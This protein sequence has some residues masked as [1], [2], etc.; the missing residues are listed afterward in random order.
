MGLY[1]LGMSRVPTLN[2]QGSPQNID[3]HCKQILRCRYALF[4][5][6]SGSVWGYLAAV[7]FI[8]A[9]MRK[10]FYQVR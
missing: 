4:G 9:Y 7:A 8:R 1:C 6:L 10:R 2:T 5:I 3:P